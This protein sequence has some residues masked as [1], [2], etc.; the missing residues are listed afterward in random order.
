MTSALRNFIISFLA[1]EDP[2]ADHVEIDSLRVMA[3]AN[4]IEAQ[5]EITIDDEILEHMTSIDSACA[6]LEPLFSRQGVQ[7]CMSE[8]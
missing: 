1:S 5:F 8:E 2:V 6:A 4:A 7:P 3:L